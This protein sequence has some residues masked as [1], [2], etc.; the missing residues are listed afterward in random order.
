MTVFSKHLKVQIRILQQVAQPFP[1]SR[2]SF[3]EQSAVVV[4]V[5]FAEL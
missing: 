3:A 4:A 2:Y 1:F 5:Q